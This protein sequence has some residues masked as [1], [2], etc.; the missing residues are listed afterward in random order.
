MKR[1]MELAELGRAQ[2]SP[3]PVVGCVIVHQGKI[4]GEGY[5]RKY[6][7][8]HA[9]PNAIDTVMDAQLLIESTVYVTLEPCAHYGKTPP[10]ASLLVDKKVKKV[11]IGAI[12]TNPLVGGK[13]LA[14][15]KSAGIEVITGVLEGEIRIQNKRFFTYMEKKRPY[16]ILKWAQTQDGFIAREN[17]DSKWISNDYSRQL[18]HKWRT[19]EDAIMVGTN[20]VEHDNPKLNVREWAGKDPLRVVIDKNLRLDPKLD[21]FDKTQ[22]T[23]I[24]NLHKDS[25]EENLSFIKLSADFQTKD[26][27]EDLYQ[28]KIQS[29]LVEGGSFLIN[30]LIEEELW[31]EARVFTG[32]I[33]FGKGIEAPKIIG[34]LEESV[35]VNTDKLEFYK[36]RE[37]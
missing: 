26:I 10:C 24:Y 1:A 9:E 23:V 15:L 22:P 28:R 36:R 13:G 31:D 16:I 14:I 35:F 27:L 30:R 4:I 32:N 2:T 12:D 3:N 18:V 37:K 29:V 34:K 7:E 21:V 20:T 33:S 6:G 8:A 19:E 17:Y 5:H 11:V 25:E